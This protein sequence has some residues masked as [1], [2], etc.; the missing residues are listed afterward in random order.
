MCVSR[1]ESRRREDYTSSL[2]VSVIWGNGRR[3]PPNFGDN[4]S[5]R[6]RWEKF[7]N[8]GRRWPPTRSRRFDRVEGHLRPSFANVSQQRFVWSSTYVHAFI[9]GNVGTKENEVLH[10]CLSGLCGRRSLSLTA[11]LTAYASVNRAEQFAWSVLVSYR[12]SHMTSVTRL[13]MG[14]C[15]L[16]YEKLHAVKLYGMCIIVWYIHPYIQ[17]FYCC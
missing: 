1:T 5:S 2:V 7:V 13:L 6:I 3:T 16:R 4:L 15:Q 10:A 8:D 12:G 9:V 17:T 11:E 14:S